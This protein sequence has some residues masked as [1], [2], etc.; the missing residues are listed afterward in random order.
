MKNN[1]KSSLYKKNIYI[2]IYIYIYA[3]SIYYIKI[4]YTNK[5]FNFCNINQHF[6]INI[7]VYL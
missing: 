2:Y 1:V 6:H 5:L 7:R 4:N 3:W